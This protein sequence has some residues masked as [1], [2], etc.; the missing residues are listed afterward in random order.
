M[1]GVQDS[2]SGRL[3]RQRVCDECYAGLEI[4]KEVQVGVGDQEKFNPA[5]QAMVRIIVHEVRLQRQ[6]GAGRPSRG[7]GIDGCG[8][9]PAVGDVGFSLSEP[10]QPPQAPKLEPLTG[11]RRC[12][13][14][15]CRIRVAKKQVGKTRSM[16][17]VDPQWG[18]MFT[19]RV[20]LTCRSA[21]YAVVDLFDRRSKMNSDEIIGRCRIPLH[22]I[23]CGA[24]R[25][26]WHRLFQVAGNGVAVGMLHVTV[27]RLNGDPM[28]S[29]IPRLPF[30]EL[31]VSVAPALEPPK[32]HELYPPGSFLHSHLFLRVGQ[33]EDDFVPQ[34]ERI[35]EAF[36]GA[37]M[38][39]VGRSNVNGATGDADGASSDVGKGSFILTTH[40]AIFITSDLSQQGRGEQ[41]RARVGIMQLPIAMIRG[42]HVKRRWRDHLA[43]I[44]LTCR[45]C[46]LYCF[47]FAPGSSLQEDIICMQAVQRV[48]EHIYWLKVEDEFAHRSRESPPAA[49]EKSLSLQDPQQ[50]VVGARCARLCGE[51]KRQGCL[52]APGWRM[53]LAN[54]QFELCRT[55]PQR[56]VVPSAC[57]DRD[58]RRASQWR[59]RCRI[60]CLTWLN[61]ITGA[62]LV[63]SSQP[64][65]G[66]MGGGCP[67]DETLLAEIRQ[68]AS[69]FA[70][71]PSSSVLARDL[72]AM[73][74]D[75]G[76]Q[77]DD[78][79]AVVESWT[80]RDYSSAPLASTHLQRRLHIV[81]ARPLLAAKGNTLLGKGHEILG[82]IGGESR[83]TLEFLDI[84]NIHTVRESHVLFV[85]ACCAEDDFQWF[86]ALHDTSWLVHVRNLLRGAVNISQKLWDGDPVLV[87][88]SD[89]WDRTSQLCSLAQL[90][91]DPFYRT[92]QGLEALI[93]KDWCSFGHQV[94]RIL[95][96]RQPCF[97]HL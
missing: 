13:A 87:H 38:H 53:S 70:T 46:R 25:D 28:K 36:D 43:A 75:E 29:A 90:L 1:L 97:F 72:I 89:G 86:S 67:E 69:S 59:S 26:D 54:N 63:R 4:T 56:L 65:T 9:P 8:T 83:A 82:R 15:F 7:L 57:S 79:A 66:F 78:C 16:D 52:N 2:K 62:A 61:P 42:T 60:P 80:F 88:C 95:L 39:L 91:L 76:Q 93:E 17:G 45:D 84:P 14:A 71:C 34:N 81:D 5:T 12:S 44:E 41:R 74:L 73:R 33:G 48:E 85:R 47:G 64:M 40:R 51:Y 10:S 49:C 58:I 92:I 50:E 11:G 6:N 19:F 30:A 35:L 20:T 68:T 55:Y 37:R 32:L 94:S 27:E 22:N 3:A 96:A 21:S 24:A 18:E 77:R 31:C 23:Q